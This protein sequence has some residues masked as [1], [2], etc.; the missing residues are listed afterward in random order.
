MSDIC[1]VGE[2]AEAPNISLPFKRIETVNMFMCAINKS[3]HLDF[4]RT[5]IYLHF[6]TNISACL[7]DKDYRS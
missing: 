3:F 6:N 2:N 7:S 4:I 1:A 5:Q